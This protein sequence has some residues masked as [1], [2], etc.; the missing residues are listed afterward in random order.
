MAAV[1]LTVSGEVVVTSVHGPLR[2]LAVVSQKPDVHD[3]VSCLP[4]RV[5]VKGRNVP[6]VK[7]NALLVAAM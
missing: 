1:A 6:L 7:L 4:D 2:S 5:K 3:S